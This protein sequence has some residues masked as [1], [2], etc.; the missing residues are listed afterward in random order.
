[1]VYDCSVVTRLSDTDIEF[2]QFCRMRQSTSGQP[3][4]D[5]LLLLPVST[6]FCFTEVVRDTT[7]VSTGTIIII[8]ITKTCKSP[9]TGAQRRRTV[10]C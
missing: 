3:P 4:L 10:P 9:L 5:Q 7:V 2:I 8:I 6:L 1:M